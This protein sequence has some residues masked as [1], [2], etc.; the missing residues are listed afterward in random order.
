[1]QPFKWTKA[2][3]VFLPEVDAEH[4]NLFRLAQELQQAMEAGAEAP[5]IQT[6]IQSL[7][8]S[9]EEHFAHEERLMKSSGCESFDWHKEQHDTVRKRAKRFAQRFA[10]GDAAA[11]AELLECLAHWFKDHI[12]LT[13]RMMGSQVRN[14]GRLE[15]S[16][17]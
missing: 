14:H 9:I 1:M 16:A 11:A 3:S 6:L 5:R 2:H 15:A 8:G 4:R 10:A 12:G 13:D 17:R 7:L